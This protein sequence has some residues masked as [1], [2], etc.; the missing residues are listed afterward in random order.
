MTCYYA[1][2][3]QVVSSSG[4]SP[5]WPPMMMATAAMAAS[6]CDRGDTRKKLQ[7]TV[8][9]LVRTLLLACIIARGV[10]ALIRVAFRV[11]VV[12]PARSLVAVAGA[13]FSAVNARCAWC[14]EQ[15][16]LGRSCTGTVLGD[17]VVGAMASSW[18]LLL[19]GITSLV[20]LCARGADEY[21]R[22]PPSPLVLTAHGKPA[23]HPQQVRVHLWVLQTCS[24]QS[25][26]EFGTW[27]FLVLNASLL[28]PSFFNKKFIHDPSQD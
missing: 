2:L 21:V 11:A 4:L 20:F 27:S 3:S 10:L 26:T 7:I 15:A 1:L 24:V 9:F 23:S 12:A 14:L 6:S 28:F 18:R 16:A 19:Q 25:L 22:P 5:G 17:A 8:V 13:A